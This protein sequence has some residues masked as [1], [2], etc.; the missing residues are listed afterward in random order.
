MANTDGPFGLRPGRLLDGSPYNGATNP[1]K[2]TAAYNTTIYRGDPVKM[3]TTGYVALAAAGDTILGVAMGFRYRDASGSMQFPKYWP[4]STATFQS[5]DWEILVA[6]DPDIIFEAQND[7]DSVTPS[8]ALVGAN[9]DFIS[10]HTGS[11]VT[12]FSKV[13][14]DTST[15]TSAT[16][17]LRLLRFVHRVDNEVGN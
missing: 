8:Q 7:S 14:I 4:A 9:A 5:E 1:Y 13:E 16:A 2:A 10:T 6:D 17:N 3:Q 12:G 11:T 15:A